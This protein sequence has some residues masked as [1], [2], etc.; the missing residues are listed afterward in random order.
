[1]LLIDM[2]TPG[3]RG[4]ADRADRRRPR[5]QRGVVRR[6]AGAG[7]PWSA[8][9]TAAGTTRSS[10]SATSGS[11]SRPVGA[12]KR[13]LRRPKEQR[14]RPA[15]R[16]AGRAPGSPS[17]RT[18]CSPSSSPRCAWSRTPPDGKPHPASSVLKLK[19]TELQQAVSELVVDLAG[20]ASL[21][22]GAGDDSPLEQW[23]RRVR[24]DLPQPPQG[25][26]LRRLQ[27]GPAPDHRP[28]DPGTL[29]D[30]MDFTYDDEQQA[31]REAVRGL[32]GKAYADFEDAAPDRRRGPGLRRE[33]VGPAGRD[34]RPRAAVRRGGRRRRAPARSSSASCARSSAGCS[35]PS[36]S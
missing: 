2:T 25:L 7:R 6:R 12:T 22:S 18:S 4:A 32:V 31:L 3:R 15:G 34:G 23:A 33:A 9:S 27:R 26:D 1:M 14:R 20:P 36:R 16:P 28:H 17:S 24:A 10:C 21:A 29:R 30:D 5:G 19:G 35:R 8:S 13:V 11:A